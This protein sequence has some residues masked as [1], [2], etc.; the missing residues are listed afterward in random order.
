[1]KRLLFFLKLCLVCFFF[2]NSSIAFAY[3]QTE[4]S[5]CIANANKNPALDK[6]SQEQIQSYCTCALEFIIDQ[7]KNVQE[8]GYKCAV[9][10]FS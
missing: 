5:E 10:N 6:I 9:M 4:L 1:M 7:G 8:S 2:F 3:D